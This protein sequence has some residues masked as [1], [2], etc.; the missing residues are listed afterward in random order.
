MQLNNLYVLKVWDCQFQIN[1]ES[2]GLFM[3]GMS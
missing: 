2:I 1:E 3:F